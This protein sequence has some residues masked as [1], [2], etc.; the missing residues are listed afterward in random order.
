MIKTDIVQVSF[1]REALGATVSA[2]IDIDVPTAPTPKMM[3]AIAELVNKSSK[4]TIRQGRNTPNVEMIKRIQMH[5]LLGKISDQRIAEELGCSRSFVSEKRR[6]LG[7]PACPLKVC[8]SQSIR[9]YKSPT[10]SKILAHKEELG[11]LSDSAFGKKYKVSQT[12]VSSM[13]RALGIAKNYEFRGTHISVINA[14]RKAAEATEVVK[15]KTE[16][17]KRTSPLHTSHTGA[18]KLLRTSYRKRLGKCF[19][20]ELAAELGCSRSTVYYARKS[21]CIPA[22]MADPKERCALARKILAQKRVKKDMPIPSP[23]PAKIA[24]SKKVPMQTL[25]SAPLYNKVLAS[26]L[27]GKISDSDLAKRM[28]C[29]SQRINQIRVKEGVATY[30]PPS[31]PTRIKVLENVHL[32]G[33]MPDYAVAEEL[34]VGVGIVYAIRHSMNIPACPAW[35]E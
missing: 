34:Q 3:N 18:S 28:N 10:K 12:Y 26:G 2:R 8:R 22:F 25:R 15:A 27:L 32:L 24:A 33:N 31:S 19:D 20:K 30:V 5:K 11:Q 1:V 21:F 4:L 23:K 14:E 7:V 35:L 13:R 6:E 16:M 29:S 17:H 9:S